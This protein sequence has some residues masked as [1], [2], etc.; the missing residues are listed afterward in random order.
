[1]INNSLTL[2]LDAAANGDTL[3]VNQLISDGVEV[4][5]VNDKGWSPLVMAAF[6]QHLDTVKLLIASGANVN[7]QSVNGTTVFM[8]A[9][10]KVLNT[11]DYSILDYLLNK[12]AKI[13]LRDFTKKWTVLQYVRNINHAGM[14]QYLIDKGASI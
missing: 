9:K 2:L 1:L 10:T 13:N 5:C 12:G 14:E 8:Y 3:S 4:N 6:N 7:H 11:G